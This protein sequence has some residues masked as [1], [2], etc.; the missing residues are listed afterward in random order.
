MKTLTLAILLATTVA[1]G[2]GE[3]GSKVY[4]GQVKNAQKPAS[5][6]ALDVF[7]A[8]PEYL[9][10][11]RRGL[12][13]DDPEYWSLLNRANEKFLEAVIR[14]ARAGGY[15]VVVEK[16]SVEFD[17]DPPDITQSTIEALE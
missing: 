7:N 16:G 3:P 4:Y 2:Y 6:T 8:I 12:T 14:T 1:A 5:L 13:Q 10:I 17:Q 15:D 11:K 9:E